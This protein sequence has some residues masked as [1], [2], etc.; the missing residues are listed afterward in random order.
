MA[1]SS[2]LIDV[3]EDKDELQN[4]PLLSRVEHSRVWRQQVMVDYDSMS[5]VKEMLS[6]GILFVRGNYDFKLVL[7]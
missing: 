5:G 7:L 2:K 4:V 6:F 1:P 3:L